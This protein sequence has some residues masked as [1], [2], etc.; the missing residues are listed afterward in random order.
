MVKGSPRGVVNIELRWGSRIVS[1]VLKKELG[2]VIV[3][4]RR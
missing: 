2:V 4:I 3:V 1:V